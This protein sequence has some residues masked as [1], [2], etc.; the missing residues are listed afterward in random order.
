MQAG[1][2]KLQTQTREWKQHK[3]LACWQ[4]ESNQ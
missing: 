2:E 3:T 1:N 4:K